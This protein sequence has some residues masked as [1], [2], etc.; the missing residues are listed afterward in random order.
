MVK[1]TKMTPFFKFN[2]C[3]PQMVIKAKVLTKSDLPFI[4]NSLDP[5]D[6]ILDGNNK[7]DSLPTL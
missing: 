7:V 4:H 1:M 3:H 2:S 5:T 6:Q